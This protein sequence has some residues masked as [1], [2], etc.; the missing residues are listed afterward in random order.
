[1]QRNH[2]ADLIEMTHCTVKSREEKG[3]SAVTQLVNRGE[4]RP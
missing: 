3:L 4:V 1:M 2:K